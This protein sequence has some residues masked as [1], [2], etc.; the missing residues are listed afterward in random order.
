[1][2][3]SVITRNSVKSNKNECPKLEMSGQPLLLE[4]DVQPIDRE[5]NRQTTDTVKYKETLR[6]TDRQTSKE[7]HR[8][9]DRQTKKHIHRQTDR[10]RNTQ[11]DR[12]TKKHT[13]TQTD[14]QRQID[15]QTNRQT[16]STINP[17]SCCCEVSYNCTA[18]KV[19][20]LHG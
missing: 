11:T 4:H 8:Q 5:G 1:M 19:R 15:R 10:Q 7:T 20:T 6:Q 16:Y 3:M 13:H 18:Y 12:Q 14:R 2:L 17:R 9:T